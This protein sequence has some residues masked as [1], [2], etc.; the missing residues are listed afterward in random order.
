[1][2]GT[3]HRRLLLRRALAWILPLLVL[4]FCAWVAMHW[5]WARDLRSDLENQLGTLEDVR[6]LRGDLEWLRSNGLNGETQ[7][8]TLTPTLQTAGT[9][10]RR[11]GDLEV[12]EAGQF[13]FR[14]LELALDALH[15]WPQ[16]QQGAADATPLP[17][18]AFW[19]HCDNAISAATSVE[20][21]QQHRV[22]GLLR[23]LD[24]HWQRFNYLILGCLIL[25]LT[26]VGLLRLAR[27]R[28]RQLSHV[29]EESSRRASRDALTGLWNRDA[30]LKLLRE[31]LSRSTR[32]NTPVGLALADIDNFTETHLLLGD[33]EGDFIIEQMSA[34]MQAHMRPYDSLGRL[35]GHT[36]L[37]LLPTCDPSATRMVAERLQDALNQHDVEHAMGRIRITTSLVYTTITSETK[38]ADAHLLVHRMQESLV[39]VR[40]NGEKGQLLGLDERAG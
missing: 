9:W 12:D 10:V 23:G 26:N 19:D 37:V 14:R 2:S 30:I 13:A 4:V 5:S 7:P 11:M 36:F 39:E 1:M 29:R 34:R 31:E 24:L 21:R 28:R 17:D 25:G 38:N 22:T 18:A 15:R 20:A 33:Q 6:R 3:P 35:E 27:G 40:C 16:P 8:G 32:S